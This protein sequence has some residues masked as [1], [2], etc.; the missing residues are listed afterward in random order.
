MLSIATV[1]IKSNPSHR[2]I[3]SVHAYLSGGYEHA[4]TKLDTANNADGFYT[5]NIGDSKNGTTSITYYAYDGSAWWNNVFSKHENMFMVLCGHDSTPTPLLNQRTGENGNNVFELLVDTSWYDVDTSK[6]AY[7][8][9]GALMVLN[10]DEDGNKLH[11]EYV[12][13]EES[14]KQIAIYGYTKITNLYSDYYTIETATALSYEDLPDAIQ[15][16]IKPVT[17]DGAS[18]RISTENAGLR[19]KTNIIKSELDA[20]VEKYG[21]ENVSVG[22][23]IAPLDILEGKG[24][25]VADNK[26]DAFTYENTNLT[27]KVD[28]VAV[29]VPQTKEGEYVGFRKN[30]FS[31]GT[32][33]NDDDT[34]YYTFAGS[35]ANIKIKNLGREFVGRGYISY[36]D[37]NGETHYIYS[38]T[39]C[40][41]SIDSVATAALKDTGRYSKAQIDILEMLTVA[42]YNDPFK[43][44][45]FYVAEN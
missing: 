34:E 39:V 28:F 11:L 8:G 42:Y 40:T 30:A 13:P 10:F 29:V 17:K 16:T 36:V 4:F 7:Y 44:D 35:L 6:S 26:C 15:N 1:S 32:L 3:A 18:V 43:E 21:E 45:P 38:D 5:E 31:V 20:L 23:L 9:S 27:L 25:T 41:R 2:V 14:N 22:T 24:L 12:A 19:F 37:F 33:S